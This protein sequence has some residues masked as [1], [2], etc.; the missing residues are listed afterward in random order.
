MGKIGSLFSAL[1]SLLSLLVRFS[2]SLLQYGS[3][4]LSLCFSTFLLGKYTVRAIQSRKELLELVY[5]RDPQK[6]GAVLASLF[7][8]V[9]VFQHF[10]VLS[11][12][13]N[14][15]L[16]LLLATVGFRVFK[17]AEA[18]FKKLPDA[19]AN[20]YQQYLDMEVAVPMDKLH[21]HVDLAVEYALFLAKK[22]RHIYLS[23][24]L[25]DSMKFGLIL[26]SLS[27]VA[28]WFSGL[29]LFVLFVLAVFTVPKTYELYKEPID[30][31]VNLAKEQLELFSNLLQ[32][33]LPFLKSPVP[34][35]KGE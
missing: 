34:E 6:S 5:W 21:H 35:K 1:S 24:A 4:A 12:L 25:L 26:H 10:S 7:L 19:G 22:I 8:C 33:K 23:D 13:I 2:L 29:S 3:L 16:C 9:Y 31:Y 20:P 18:H 14:G 27:Y 11:V 28:S 30:G 32:E 15:A 17:L